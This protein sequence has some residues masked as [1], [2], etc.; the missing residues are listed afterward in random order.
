MQYPGN[1][2]LQPDYRAIAIDST[3]FVERL[4]VLDASLFAEVESTDSFASFSG[5]V[6]RSTRKD[7]IDALC[8]LD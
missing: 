4:F 2:E 8:D 6:F 7:V 1:S 3:E 5:R